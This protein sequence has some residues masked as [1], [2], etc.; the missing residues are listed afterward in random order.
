LEFGA[1]DFGGFVGFLGVPGF[2]A[3]GRIWDES[4]VQKR[5]FGTCARLCQQLSAP[6]MPNA[7]MVFGARA[8]PIGRDGE[9]LFGA[10]KAIYNVPQLFKGTP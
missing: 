10:V 8:S 6:Q 7:I 2:F 5:A 3:M 4:G 9:T 1:L